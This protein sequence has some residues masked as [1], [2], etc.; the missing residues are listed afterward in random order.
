MRNI[1]VVF[2]LIF[3]G[4]AIWKASD[5]KEP[6]QAARVQLTSSGQSTDSGIQTLTQ[7]GKQPAINAV[8]DINQQEEETVEPESAPKAGDKTPTNEDITSRINMQDNSEGMPQSSKQYE[9]LIIPSLKVNTN[10]TSKPYSELSWDL[11]TLGHDVAALEDIPGRT[12]ENNVILAGHI[13]VR[14]GSHGPFRYL[15]KLSPGDKIILHDEQLTYTYIVRDQMLVYPEENSALEDTS[16]PQLTLITCHTWDEETL[17]YLRR[18][19]VFA[20]LE[21]IEIR[22]ILID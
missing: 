18:L 5:R 6:V 14:N 10:V 3:L 21:K 11:T 7:V 4:I 17:S 22:E 1:G 8:D 16:Q 12:T 13:T 9:R 19:I 15:W 20:D 2:L